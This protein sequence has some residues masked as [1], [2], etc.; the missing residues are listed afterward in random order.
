MPPAQGFHYI[1]LARCDLS[2]WVEGRAIRKKKASVVAKFLFEEIICR[3]TMPGQITCDGG[4]EF[5]KEVNT[6]LERYRIPK[7]KTTAYHPEGNGMLERGNRPIKEAIIRSCGGKLSDWPNQLHLALYADRVT[8]KRTTGMTPYSLKHGGSA[9]LPLDHTEATFIV[10]GWEEVES[11]EDLLAMRMRQL[12]K[13]DEDQELA[14]IR[15]HIART[16]SADDRNRAFQHVLQDKANN[17]LK[18][19]DLV[20]VR[21]SYLEMQQGK[22]FEDRY[23]GP[24]TVRGRTSKGAYLLDELDGAPIERSVAANR[25]KRYYRRADLDVDQLARQGAEELGREAHPDKADR[26]APEPEQ[27]QEQQLQQKIDGSSDEEQDDES[28]DPLAVWSTRAE[29]VTVGEKPAVSR[30]AFF[31]P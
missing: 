30:K 31:R 20:L 28:D 22:K 12:E 3:G 24:F 14:Q 11:T 8:T 9:T 25:T 6:L 19:G 15:L 4:T 10:R 29:W 18:I 26:A 1:I 21:N 5:M 2:G 13:R 23:F 7:I 16:R 17:P 27:Q